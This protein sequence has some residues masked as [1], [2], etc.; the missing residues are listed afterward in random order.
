MEVGKS[1]FSVPLLHLKHLI[2]HRVQYD[3]TVFD[4]LYNLAAAVPQLQTLSITKNERSY[5]D[6]EHVRSPRI[7]CVDVFTSVTSLEIGFDDLEDYDVSIERLATAFPSLQQAYFYIGDTIFLG[8]EQQKPKQ[9]PIRAFRELKE[10]LCNH[11]VVLSRLECPTITTLKIGA[12]Q[13]VVELEHLLEWV[14]PNVYTALEQ[15]QIRIAIPCISYV[16]NLRGID[17]DRSVMVSS[18]HEH[19]MADESTPT[20]MKMYDDG[21]SPFISR[22]LKEIDRLVRCVKALLEHSPLPLC[23]RWVNKTDRNSGYE[24][25]YEYVAKRKPTW[26]LES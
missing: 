3:Y 15:V 16:I 19:C 22:C 23:I 7:D 21:A 1:I 2:L 14:Q 4:L 9:P 5:Y 18:M 6:T 13:S 10:L 12:Q 24:P 17:L 8:E 26:T 20:S 11:V 25:F